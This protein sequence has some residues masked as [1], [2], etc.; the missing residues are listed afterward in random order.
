MREATF[1]GGIAYSASFK[2]LVNGAD[3]LCVTPLLSNGKISRKYQ[4]ERF[5]DVAVDEACNMNRRENGGGQL[6]P[7]ASREQL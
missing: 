6:G 1:R 5:K 2:D 4:D 7:A 3:L